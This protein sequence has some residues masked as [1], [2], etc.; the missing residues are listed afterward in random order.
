MFTGRYQWNKHLPTGH[1][2]F[3]PSF[4][5]CQ[6]V[7]ACAGHKQS[8]CTFPEWLQGWAVVLWICSMLQWCS[9]CLSLWERV[10][11]GLLTGEAW[12]T[13][14]LCC[15]TCRADGEQQGSVGPVWSCD[16]ERKYREKH[17][18][19]ASG[20]LSFVKGPFFCKEKLAHAI[21]TAFQADSAQA[22]VFFLI[23]LRCLHQKW[24]LHNVFFSSGKC[25]L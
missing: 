21:S 14:T 17:S 22:C 3:S 18:G 7:V 10:F 8:F 16:F 25:L 24:K 23:F 6:R 19:W 11:K 9:A 15:F 13:P 2:L 4:S 1:P 5:T 20:H 12:N